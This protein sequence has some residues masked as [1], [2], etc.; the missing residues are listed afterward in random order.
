MSRAGSC[1]VVFEP[2]AI[3][4]QDYPYPPATCYPDKS[5]AVTEVLD[6][7]FDFPIRL[8]VKPCDVLFVTREQKQEMVEFCTRH[9]VAVINRYEPWSLVLDPFLDTSF[10][11]EDQ[12]RTIGILEFNG[13]TRQQCE[14]WRKQFKRVMLSYN[15]N[16]MLWEWVSLG[17]TDLLDAHRGILAASKYKLSPD[18]FERLYRTV[19]EVLFNAREVRS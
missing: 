9:A 11:K 7:S 19:I 3:R 10:D 17:A 12:E 1:R 6:V 2:S 18:E 15:F 13:V 16:S 5:V 8:R 4:F 14:Q